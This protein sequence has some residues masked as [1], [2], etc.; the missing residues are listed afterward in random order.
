M[1]FYSRLENRMFCSRNFYIFWPFA[2]FLPAF[3]F[4]S[5]HDFWTKY[6]ENTLIF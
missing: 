6:N 1:K 4:K 3:D 5:G 2:H